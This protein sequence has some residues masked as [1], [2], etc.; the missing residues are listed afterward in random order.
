MRH[1]QRISFIVGLALTALVFLTVQPARA[2]VS[3][4][5]ATIG[6]PEP[7]TFLLV[8]SGV[9]GLA[10]LAWRRRG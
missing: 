6:V 4:F 3:N 7:G 9:A 8:A 5:D 2:S 10:G 1:W